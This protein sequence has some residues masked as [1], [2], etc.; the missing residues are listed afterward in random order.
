M[1][2]EGDL[3]L[4]ASDGLFD[5]LSEDSILELCEP[6]ADSPAESPLTGPSP[7]SSPS[8]SSPIADGLDAAASSAAA[9]SASAGA[10]SAAYA[11]TSASGGAGASANGD[12]SD[13]DQAAMGQLQRVADSLVHRAL[14]LSGDPEYMSPFSIE[15]RQHGIDTRGGR[16]FISHLILVLHEFHRLPFNRDLFIP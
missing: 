14:E 6:L 9:A 5:N 15:A 13:R 4:V 11:S 2:H 8:Q 7:S 1:L 3:I 12:R 16:T 10:A